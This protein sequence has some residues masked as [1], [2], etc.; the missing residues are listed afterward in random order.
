MK[1]Y[2][3]LYIVAFLILSC[4]PAKR[5]LS[6]T[7]TYLEIQSQTE[8]TAVNKIIAPYKTSLYAEMNKVIG[9]SD[10][11][12]AKTKDM[13]ETLLGNFVAD[14]VLEFSKTID[15]ET[16]FAVLN[17]GGLRSSLPMGN[18]T[19]GNVYELMPFD[20]EI[21]IVTLDGNNVQKVFSYIAEKAGVPVSG[22]T[23]QLE[24]MNGTQVPYNIKVGAEKFSQDN[25]YQIAT[26]DYLANG[27]DNMNFW[28]KGSIQ[29]TSK[30]LRDAIIDHIRFKTDSQLHLNPSLDGRI[31][32]LV[33]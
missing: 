6:S 26:S 3:Y 4:Q 15:P 30:K 2:S 8:E 20:N 10:V 16:D 28:S 17:N 7:A 19:V 32:Y 29:S 21:V 5:N 33:R 25:T 12:M 23:L 14:L 24:K 18:I 1:K 31:S 11:A 22:V 13:P 9:I 27:G